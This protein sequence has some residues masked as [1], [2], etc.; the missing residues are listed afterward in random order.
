MTG[1]VP[2]L[3]VTLPG[4]TIEALRGEI[5]D[6]R[7]AGAD[8]AEVRLDRL[9]PTERE[10]I[11]QL[12]PAALPLLATLRSRTE[13]GEGPDRPEERGPILEAAAQLPFLW[14]DLEEAR[15]LP[16]AGRLRPG[17]HSIQVLSAHLPAATPPAELIR[18]AH[19]APP[20]GT[21]RKLVVASS[22]GDLLGE[23]LPS[24]EATATDSTVVLTT[25]ASG[26]LLRAWSMRL[27]FPFVFA[28]LPSDRIRDAEA[29]VEPS[30]IP[31]DRLRFFFE[32]GA[33]RPIFALL[34]RPVAHSQS[35]YLH[36]RW[37]RSLGHR[38]LYVALDI[39]SESEFVE[40]LGPL[41]AHGVLGVNVTH[42]WKSAALASATRVG[43]G[44]EL[45]GTANCLTFDG[46]D[47]AAENTDLVAILRRLEELR[48]DGGWDGSEL[49]V[50]GAGGA[51]AATLAAARELQVRGAV[52]ARSTER[53]A[54]LAERFGATSVAP[55]EPRAFPLVVHATDVGRGDGGPLEV[56]LRDFL[57][58]GGRVLD[59]VYSAD[60][61]VVREAAAAARA[62]YEDGWRLL[63]YQAAAS[64]G[65]WWGSEPQ[66]GELARTIEEG[67]C[68]G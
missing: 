12:F 42:P 30:Q 26:P 39:A 8:V 32:G 57:A 61:P 18:R 47:V 67:P 31:V 15:D 22:V 40:A 51:A 23:I 65:I 56:P 54:A 27:R 3:I 21:L 33:D 49:L 44:A 62:T 52:V 6:A 7:T 63:A 37:M 11:S 13:G 28:R 2:L 46:G 68:T 55:T 4:R 64:F 17:G 35:P 38:G 60:V 45:C 41:A 16:L 5:P 29:P 20:P 66:P 14:L 24:L 19:V 10:R 58:P 9:P 36:S 53:A 59:W 25:G 43:R 34:G 48:G 1:D 50:V